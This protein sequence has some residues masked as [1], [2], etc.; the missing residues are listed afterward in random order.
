MNVILPENTALFSLPG[1]PPGPNAN[2]ALSGSKIM[3]SQILY[4]AHV[5]NDPGPRA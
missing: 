4:F 3:L 2:S 5:L 1:K